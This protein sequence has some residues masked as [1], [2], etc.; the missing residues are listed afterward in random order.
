MN[1]A[2]IVADCYQMYIHVV[3]KKSFENQKNKKLI[4]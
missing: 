3:F 1:D 4:E 2:G